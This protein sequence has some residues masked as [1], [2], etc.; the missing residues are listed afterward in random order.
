MGASFRDAVSPFTRR[1]WVP[2]GT[3]SNALLSGK[4][5]AFSQHL[6]SP[7]GVCGFVR[8]V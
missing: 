3:K 4:S 8:G 1:S 6:A 7:G 2:G 5:Q